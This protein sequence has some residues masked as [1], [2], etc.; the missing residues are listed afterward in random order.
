MSAM[1]P[2][3]DKLEA[4]VIMTSFSVAV[5]RIVCISNRHIMCIVHH[6][7]LWHFLSILCSYGNVFSQQGLS[8]F[9]APNTK[10]ESYDHAFFTYPVNVHVVN[11]HVVLKVKRWV[12]HVVESYSCWN[13][14]ICWKSVYGEA[15]ALR[16]V[17]EDVN[18]F[19]LQH[20]YTHAMYL[21]TYWYELSRVLIPL[22]CLSLVIRK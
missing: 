18:R 5:L 16:Q 1:E 2:A 15:K 21:N 7:F 9:L 11:V 3:V 6:V 4:L 8:L 19:P 10:I 12:T 20:F 13:L 14:C 17:W 22:R